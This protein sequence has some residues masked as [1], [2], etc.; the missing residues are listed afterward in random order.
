MYFSY[1][2]KNKLR[3]IF[4]SE[5]DAKSYYVVD[6]SANRALVVVSHT[7][8]LSHLYVSDDLNGEDGHVHFTL[9]LEAVFSYFPNSTW[10]ESFIQ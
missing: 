7:D 8:T 3:C 4:N 9:S 6:V 5:L 2:L 1:K 10:N